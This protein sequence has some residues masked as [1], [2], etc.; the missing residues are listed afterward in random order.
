MLE[1]QHLRRAR[2][3]RK[4]RLCLLAFLAAERRIHQHH[5]KQLRRVQEQP[6][7]RLRAGQCVA[8]PDVRL[9]NVVQHQIGQRDGIDRVVLLSAV[10]RAALE[11][12]ELFRRAD[13]GVAGPGHVFEGLRQE[14]A[15]AAAGIVHRLIHLG[16]DDADHRPDDLARGEEL[17][18]VVSLLTH[19][20]QQPLVDL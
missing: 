6:A 12:L 8:M 5:V 17:A 18:A 4:P 13:L 16:V 1:K 7:V 3:V 20:E 15:G 14:A 2:F 9:V 11:G 19:L 10:E